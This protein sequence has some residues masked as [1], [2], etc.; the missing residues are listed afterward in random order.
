MMAGSDGWAL[1]AATASRRPCTLVTWKAA[2]RARP[3]R[4]SRPGRQRRLVA[5]RAETV[6]DFLE[7]HM[8][9]LRI[10]VPACLTRPPRA[11]RTG[12]RVARALLGAV[13]TLRF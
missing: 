9:L 10:G 3:S 5:R 13:F 11:R 12:A 2:S 7:V 8:V 1:T 4:S 6:P